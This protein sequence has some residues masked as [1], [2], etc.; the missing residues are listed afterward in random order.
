MTAAL[1]NPAELG[2]HALLLLG[3][4]GQRE[5]QIARQKGLHRV[6]VEPDQ[7]A[8]EL[9]GQQALTLALFLEDDLRQDSARNVVI[10]LG[11]VDDEIHPLLHHLGEVLQGH[12]AGGCRIVE[13]PIGVLLDDHTLPELDARAG[14]LSVSHT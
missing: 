12:V 13:P 4:A 14:L 8:Q 1:A 9:D 3:E 2:A 11:I 6:A 10:R 5:L 7:L